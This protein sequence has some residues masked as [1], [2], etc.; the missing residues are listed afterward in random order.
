MCVRL[1][2]A[3]GLDLT[4]FQFDYDLTFAVFF[5]N[6]DKTIYGRYGTRS[7]VEEA[8]R[9]ISIRGLAAAMTKALA[10]H[11]GYP[12]NKDSLAG[13]QAVASKYK[14]ADDLPSLQGKYAATLD[15]PGA[16]TKSCMHCHQVRD[17]ARQV[18]RDAGKAIPNQ[19]LLPNPLPD[20]VG[21]KFDPKHA[22]VVAEVAGGSAAASAGFLPGDEL[23][24]LA[25]QPIISLAD[26]QWVLHNAGE[27]GR[28]SGVVTRDRAERTLQL[29]LPPGWRRNTD[30]SWRVSS[31][32]LRRMVTGGLLFE[33]A[34]EDQRRA[35][36]V[37][38]GKLA[39]VVK[40]VG[41]YGP[42]AAAKRAGFQEGDVVVSFDG[43]EEHMTTS[44]LLAY[45]AQHNKP[46]QRVSVV[47]VRDGQRKT[48]TLP[49]Q[50]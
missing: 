29:T 45:G 13:K 7:S 38:A 9:D 44:Q 28:L 18:Y 12:N 49:M 32:S 34:S 11:K 46:G 39:L 21:L 14:T 27:S 26:V 42:H 10:I 17:A 36:E 3:N 23:L 8:T 40:H 37:A 41:Q 2:K 47:I 20:V 50:K 19:L 5:M 35:A 31:W 30:I 4:L 6:A 25:G 43:H 16:V 22:A 48:L 24:S 15:Y 1:V 33:P